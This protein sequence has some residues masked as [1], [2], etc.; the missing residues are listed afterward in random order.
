M[1]AA[2]EHA[3]P[4]V[5]TEEQAALRASVASLLEKRSDSAAVRAAFA[6]QDGFDPALWSTLVEQ[7][8]AAALSI[9]EEHDGAGATWVETHLVCEEL[10]RGLT[11]SPMLG[12]AVLAAQAVLATGDAADAARLLPAFDSGD[13]IH[14]S[15][16]GYRA[17][18]DAVDLRLFGRN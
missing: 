13:H 3:A 9:P 10:G 6:S 12:S 2:P 7:I 16:A 14:P 17:M 11:P 15:E 18:G 8:G 4:G 1:T 5:D